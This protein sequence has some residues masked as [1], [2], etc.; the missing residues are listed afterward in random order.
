VDVIHVVCFIAGESST[1]L[2]RLLEPYAL[3]RACLLLK[4]ELA[5]SEWR[6][7]AQPELENQCWLQQ[8]H[9]DL[10]LQELRYCRLDDDVAFRFR[11]GAD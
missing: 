9:H 7:L 8:L 3:D 4:F 10:E 1:K 11:L 2:A 5:L 6:T